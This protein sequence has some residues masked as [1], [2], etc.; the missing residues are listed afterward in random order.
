MRIPDRRAFRRDMEVSGEA[1]LEVRC[2][3]VQDEA[4]GDPDDV[5]AFCAGVVP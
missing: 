3:R 1:D 2:C 5:G 4:A